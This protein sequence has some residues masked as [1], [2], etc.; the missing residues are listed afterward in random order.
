MAQPAQ[1]FSCELRTGAGRLRSG[2][3]LEQRPAVD[4]AGDGIDEVF[5]MRH[6]PQYVEPLIEDP[7]DSVPRSVRIRRAVDSAGGV[8]I[9]Q[10]DL[11][12]RLESAQGLFVRDEI[13]LSVCDRELDHLSGR[14]TP[15]KAGSR[16]LDPQML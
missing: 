13:A 11:A 1:I 16:V 9:A 14:V 6:Q 8:A 4:A 3:R 5:R 7:G 10:S 12:S 2:K 15:G